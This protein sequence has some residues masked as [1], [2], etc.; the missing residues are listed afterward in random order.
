MKRLS[1]PAHYRLI[2]GTLT[3]P[4]IFIANASFNSFAILPLT[5][6]AS[7]LV[8]YR[9]WL[10][11]LLPLL[12]ALLLFYQLVPNGLVLFALH[13]P[14]NGELR[15]T[16]GALL[17]A[18]VKI[19]FLLQLLLVSG[20]SIGNDL[21]LPGR[22]GRQIAK[23]FLCYHFFLQESKRFTIKAPFKSL[24]ALLLSVERELA[25]SSDEPILP[26]GEQPPQD[27]V[28]TLLFYIII[29]PLPCYILVLHNWY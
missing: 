1:L 8:G 28:L 4:A 26:K 13:L 22:Y 5:V 20:F 12:L 17:Q 6:L 3:L 18:A 15:L 7:Y 24:D 29:L 11:R 14:W 21:R 25:V 2:V 10:R 23:V 27:A 19:S 16:L 9:L